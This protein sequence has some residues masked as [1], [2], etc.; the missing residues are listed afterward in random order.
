[1]SLP[2]TLD[3]G[4]PSHRSGPCQPCAGVASGHWRSRLS[5]STHRAVFPALRPPTLF[6]FILSFVLMLEGKLGFLYRKSGW[7]TFRP[8]CHS[9]LLSPSHGRTSSLTSSA[10]IATHKIPPEGANEPEG[11]KLVS[12]PTAPCK[13]PS[14]RLRARSTF[15]SQLVDP[16]GK[17]VLGILYLCAQVGP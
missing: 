11:R 4:S 2:A 14:R 5:G 7:N 16:V 13:L 17:G 6:L 8:S 3:P 15:N 10:S 1:M 9:S 12:H